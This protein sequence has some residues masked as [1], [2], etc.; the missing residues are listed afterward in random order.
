MSARGEFPVAF[1]ASRI[2]GPSI[3]VVVRGAPA[4]GGLSEKSCSE[5]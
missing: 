1:C 2:T 3:G 5:P 4:A